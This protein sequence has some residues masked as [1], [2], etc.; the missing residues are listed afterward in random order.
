M[1]ILSSGEK[2]KKKK[3]KKTKNRIAQSV[4]YLVCGL[5]DSVLRFPASYRKGIRDHFPRGTVAG[6]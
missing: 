3:K 5:D 6:A 4:Q 2:K 1:S